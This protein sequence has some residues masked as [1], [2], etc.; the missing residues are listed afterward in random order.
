[1][2]DTDTV[3]FA[4]R[5]NGR[6]AQVIERRLRSEL[7]ISALTVA[8]LR[9]G[10]ARLNSA[11]LNRLIDG[12]TG[13]LAILPFDETCAGAYAKIATHLASHGSPIGV[14]DTLIA[15]HALTLDV[16]L[17][18]NNVKHFSRVR[19]LRVENWF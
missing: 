6:V 10:A 5:G 18:T 7:C 15:A 4:L 2:L 12:F 17:V 1:M 9:F 16:T 13:D 3:S 14:M 19:G 11:R 8:E